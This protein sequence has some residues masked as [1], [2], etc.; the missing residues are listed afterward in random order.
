MSD[1]ILNPQT[2]SFAYDDFIAFKKRYEEAVANKEEQ[3]VY[4]GGE[5][6]TVY[7]KYVVQYLETQFNKPNQTD[8]GN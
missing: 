6:L 4:E 5:F 8:N 7:A 2:Q 3:F 1:K